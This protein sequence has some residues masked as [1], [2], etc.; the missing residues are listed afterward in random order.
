MGK[1]LMKIAAVLSVMAVT[2]LSS[3]TAA[4]GKGAKADTDGHELVALWKEYGRLQDEDRPDKEE[5]VLE[6]I[7]SQAE[8]RHL[9]WDFYDAWREYRDAVLSR[10]WKRR[11]AVDSSLMESVRKFDEPVVT[12][13]VACNVLYVM[14]QLNY[15]KRT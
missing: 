3:G 2:A 11:E 12:Y 4:Y 5:E 1:I 9:P 14:I 13:A 8:R 10:D 6:R 15:M 7:I